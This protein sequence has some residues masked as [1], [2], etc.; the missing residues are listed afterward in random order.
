MLWLSRYECVIGVIGRS[1]EEEQLGSEEAEVWQEGNMTGKVDTRTR[2]CR[3]GEG[4]IDGEVH[5]NRIPLDW[6][7]S[8]VSRE[9]KE[10]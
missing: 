6:L 8:P 9:G 7:M 5:G 10:V 2:R 4:W 1:W 3:M